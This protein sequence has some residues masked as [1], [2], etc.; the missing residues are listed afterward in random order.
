MAA[1]KPAKPASSAAKPLANAELLRLAKGLGVVAA[2][3]IDPHTVETAPWVRWKC[4]F[5]CSCFGSSL[6][7]PPHSP[8]PE[9]TRRVLDSYRRGVLFQA[10]PGE[11]KRIAVALEREVFL[12]GRYQAFGLGSG[13]CSLCTGGCAFDQGCRHAGQARPAM[14]ACGID[15][16]ATVRKHGFTLNV[17]RDHSDEQHYF[18]LVLVD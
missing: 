11:T 10:P 16:Y 6:V 14:E 4:R 15:V 5:G 9:E 8:P 13:P 1:K 3:V 18:G 12:A 2:K 17:V 7:C